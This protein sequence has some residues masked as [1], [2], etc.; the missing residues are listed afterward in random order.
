M[1]DV[2]RQFRIPRFRFGLR[3]FF[4]IL[5][6]SAVAL[7]WLIV[8]TKRQREAIVGIR[9]VD[10]Y[11]RYASDFRP[12]S[13]DEFFNR[14]GLPTANDIPL[15]QY[16]Y[17]PNFLRD[18]IP[19]DY[20][21]RILS[22]HSVRSSDELY[23]GT[24]YV[25]DG[26]SAKTDDDFQ[27]LQNLPH[28]KEVVFVS[29]HV[30]GRC[31]QHLRAP[32]LERLLIS[33]CRRFSAEGLAGL[34]LPN[35]LKE[36]C[37]Y[38][39]PLGGN[40]LAMLEY[41]TRL[42][43][44]ALVDCYRYLPKEESSSFD[45]CSL[46]IAPLSNLKRLRQLRLCGVRIVRNDI[47]ALSELSA[48]EHLDLNDTGIT[49]ASIAAL[50]DLTNLEFLDLQ[51]TRVNG[52]G[53]HHLRKLKKLRTLKLTDSQLTDQH[54]HIFSQL[55]RLRIEGPCRATIS[56]AGLRLLPEVIE[57]DRLLLSGSTISDKMLG[58]TLP[59]FDKTS[60]LKI[61]NV[62]GLSI[63]GSGF[64]TSAASSIAEIYAANS[65][66]DDV[67]LG[68]IAAITTLRH[69]DVSNCPITEESLA[70]LVGHA[71]LR[72]LNVTGVR[73]TKRGRDYLSRIPNLDRIRGLSDSD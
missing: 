11:F 68:Q 73:I 57:T 45:V 23:F 42:E 69:L 71:S 8:T 53:V 32:K 18:R 25:M 10:G 41:A 43:R 28:L 4:A 58:E 65:Q 59:V 64:S 39:S 61:V 33:N 15:G 55:R 54:L 14:A 7:G 60:K 44:L 22:F 6:I 31:F 47:S 40:D 26:Q 63:N 1:I 30:S 72:T 46:D 16:Q 50:A 13:S 52:D 35:R 2:T 29:P 17:L 34:R 19:R 36:F 3:T 9:S 56:D 24:R 12:F 21:E 62:E 49:N 51:G 37:V 5:T 66:V 67:G 48:L 38:R 27:F 70:T 20:R